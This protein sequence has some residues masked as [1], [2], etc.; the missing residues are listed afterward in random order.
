[1]FNEFE[2]ASTAEKIETLRNS[3]E[4]K[5]NMN[6]YHKEAIKMMAELCSLPDAKEPLPLP[7]NLNDLLKHPAIHNRLHPEHG[8]AHKR[9]LELHGI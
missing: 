7:D 6:R 2:T 4:Y 8:R 9:F 1:M 3:P 5:D